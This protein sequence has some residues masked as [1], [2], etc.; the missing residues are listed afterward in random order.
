MRLI[1]ILFCM[2]MLTTPISAMTTKEYRK[3][4]YT[5]SEAILTDKADK[6]KKRIVETYLTGA[7]NAY[8]NANV[9]L[10]AKELPMLYCRTDKS[11]LNMEDLLMILNTEIDRMEKI[12]S[13]TAQVF[14]I[15]F[16]LLKGLQKTFPCDKEK[17]E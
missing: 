15:D 4:Y 12:N 3:L 9:E 11:P 13:D 2:F 14:P 17:G 16:I 7:I 6:V 1:I 8:T 5:K 10:K